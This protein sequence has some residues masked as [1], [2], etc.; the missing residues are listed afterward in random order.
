MTSPKVSVLVPNYKTPQITK[1]CLRL[2]RKNTD[3]DLIKVIVIDNG[4]ADSSIKYLRSLQWISLIERTPLQGESVGMAHASALDEGMAKVDTPYV[5]SIHTD[6]FVHHPDWLGFLLGEIAKDPNIAGVGSWKMELKPWFRRILK[7]AE[8][9]YQS[10]VYPLIGKGYGQL[11]GKGQNFYYLR[12]HCALYRTDLIRK[13]RLGF[14]LGSD[15]AGRAM[16]KSLVD[17]GH[18]MIFLPAETLTRY[19]VHINHATMVLN[20]QLGSSTQSVSTGGKRIRKTLEQINAAEIL[21]N[22][23]LDF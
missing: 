20:P 22:E 1:I 3:P 23:Q 18:Q 2:I 7:G 9:A 5:L 21:E 19:L 17:A 14:S 11:E 13:Y 15:T 4:S 8:R 12:S 16:H 6:T 10:A